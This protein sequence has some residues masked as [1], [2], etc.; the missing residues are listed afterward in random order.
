MSLLELGILEFNQQYRNIDDSTEN[1]DESSGVTHDHQIQLEKDP[2]AF[3]PVTFPQGQIA[4]SEA[5]SFTAATVLTNSCKVQIQETLGSGIS[6]GRNPHLSPLG[7]L[8]IMDWRAEK[9]DSYFG[10]EKEGGRQEMVDAVNAGTQWAQRRVL[11]VQDLFY[12]SGFRLIQCS[13]AFLIHSVIMQM[14]SP[15]TVHAVHF[16]QGRT[17]NADLAERRWVR[18]CK[19]GGAEVEEW[20]RRCV[21]M[22]AY[23]PTLPAQ[24]PSHRHRLW[25]AVSGCAGLS[26]S[27]GRGVSHRYLA[28]YPAGFSS[29]SAYYPYAAPVYRPQYSD[30]AMNPRAC[31]AYP[32]VR[33]QAYY[34]ATPM[35][36]IHTAEEGKAASTSSSFAAPIQFCASSPLEIERDTLHHRDALSLSLSLSNK[37]GSLCQLGY[38]EWNN[39]DFLNRDGHILHSFGSCST[40]YIYLLQCIFD[41]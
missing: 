8:M 23:P 38:Y 24:T 21:E 14:F 27:A 26:G 7:S 31:P 4:D 3:D 29:Q 34:P 36:Y 22:Q 10:R 16:E 11:G 6:R 9:S 19:A 28:G 18:R 13:L 1:I 15:S 40:L 39:K 20:L 2:A 35:V 33:S 41:V 12:K 30:A 32:V 5:V 25:G 37:R 17:I